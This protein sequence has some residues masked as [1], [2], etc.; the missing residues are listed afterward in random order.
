MSDED[1]GIALTAMAACDM[2]ETSTEG[3]EELGEACQHQLQAYAAVGRV[4]GKG[5]FKGSGKGKDKGKG[6]GKR[7]V[8]TQLSIQDR[9]GQT[10]QSEEEQPMPTMWRLWT[11]GR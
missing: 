10:C 9:K 7:V 6:K 8:R 1:L 11:L 2:D 4:K 5:P 3:L